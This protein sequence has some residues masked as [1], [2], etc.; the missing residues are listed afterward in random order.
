MLITLLFIYNIVLFWLK[1]V[2]LSAVY[3][4]INMVTKQS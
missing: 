2:T 3:K 4:A 1:Q